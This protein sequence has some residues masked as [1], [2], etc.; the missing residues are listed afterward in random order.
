MSISHVSP[1]TPES[2]S[3]LPPLVE[4]EN[5][6]VTLFKTI[7]EDKKNL[8]P[9]FYE[10]RIKIETFGLTD[11]KQIDQKIDGD[12]SVIFNRAFNPKSF[13][14]KMGQIYEEIEQRIAKLEKEEA[15]AKEEEEKKRVEVGLK[16]AIEEMQALNATALDAN[17]GES[18]LTALSNVDKFIDGLNLENSTALIGEL[19]QE[20][21]TLALIEN[22]PLIESGCFSN[23]K[24]LLE[25][26]RTKI[27]TLPDFKV[28]MYTKDDAAIAEIAQNEEVNAQMASDA[29]LAAALAA[30]DAGAVGHR[31]RHNN[32]PNGG[33]AAVPPAP[34]VAVNGAQAAV[35]PAPQVP[36]NG[37][38]AAVPLAP[39]VPV[40][41]AQA[42][43][44]PTKPSF[45]STLIS[46]F[47]S[48]VMAP[49]K[50]FFKLFS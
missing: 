29:A 39:Q 49:F 9:S 38:Q 12:I 37:A 20:F 11:L 23:I 26:L 3:L 43:P 17:F 18:L 42:A 21:D 50:W 36:I 2:P 8:D 48:F 32:V 27:P 7:F 28:K 34:Q 41:G 6:L 33:Q 1:I 45:F 15:Q 4:G 35:P 16:R 5:R 13:E 25:N 46:G 40:N 19:V 14:S 31:P 22:F 24:K 10:L 44:A 47:F 30:A